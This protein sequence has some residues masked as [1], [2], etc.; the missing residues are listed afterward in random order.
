MFPLF[1]LRSIC[2]GKK[3]VLE[4]HQGRSNEIGDTV[5]FLKYALVKS[6]RNSFCVAKLH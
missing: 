5:L 6:K 2:N 1:L 4:L 3:D